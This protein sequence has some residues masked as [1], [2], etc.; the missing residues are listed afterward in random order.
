MLE[1]YPYCHD[2][3]LLSSTLED[4]VVTGAIVG[5]IT[6][7]VTTV[8]WIITIIATVCI[9][10]RCSHNVHPI[11]NYEMG[12]VNPSN[13]EQVADNERYVDM[14]RI[15]TST[16]G[17]SSD[18]VTDSQRLPTSEALMQEPAPP[19]FGSQTSA[20]ED[21]TTANSAAEGEEKIVSDPAESDNF[22]FGKE[23]GWSAEA[24]DN[25]NTNQEES[26]IHV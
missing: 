24:D 15:R 18:F 22:V 9:R 14:D 23:I 16:Q 8:F 25:D 13:G 20:P 5:F 1:G 4:C 11:Q 7:A 2:F 12:L 26:L 17:P 10:R 21:P 6:M 19:N 3:S